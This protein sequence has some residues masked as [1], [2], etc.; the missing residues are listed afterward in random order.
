MTIQFLI[1]W[2]NVIS[3]YVS[4]RNAG[5]AQGVQCIADALYRLSE[6]VLDG[7]SVI[8]TEYVLN[9]LNRIAAGADQELS[10]LQ[11]VWNGVYKDSGIKIDSTQ[12]A[13]TLQHTLS[14]WQSRIRG[15]GIV[16]LAGDVRFV[17]V[18]CTVGHGKGPF[19]IHIPLRTFLSYQQLEKRIPELVKW[20]RMQ[21]YPCDSRLEVFLRCLKAFCASSMPLLPQSESLKPSSCSTVRIY[22]PYLAEMF[23]PA[24]VPA[25]KATVLPQ[26]IERRIMAWRNSFQKLFDVF[27]GNNYVQTI[28]VVT[29]LTS[30]CEAWINDAKE[31]LRLD[32]IMEG[33]VLGKFMSRN[34]DLRVDFH[35]VR[36]E[37]SFH[38]RFISNGNTCFSIGR[39]VDICLD[40]NDSLSKEFNV[41]YGCAKR[42]A[43]AAGLMVFGKAS[44]SRFLKHSLDMYPSRCVAT[45]GADM[46]GSFEVGAKMRKTADANVFSFRNPIHNTELLVSVNPYV[47]EDDF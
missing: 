18:D 1:D 5:D 15:T 13:R 8:E 2:E 14:A 33:I 36:Q 9:G 31:L 20:R 21:H 6:Y 35:F 10:S 19:Y 41:F 29:Q 12:V 44:P 28:E 43:S 26:G 24:R 23:L 11:S 22:D 3:T 47:G 16:A 30:H 46:I 40:T 32:E 37:S 25:S 34:K 38:D 7:G 39:G 45:P 17:M 42:D 27:S 4:C